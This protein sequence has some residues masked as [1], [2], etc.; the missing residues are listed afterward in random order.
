MA[1]IITLGSESLLLISSKY[2]LDAVAPQS[3]S[4]SSRSLLTILHRKMAPIT[5][6][7]ASGWKASRRAFIPPILSHP[8]LKISEV[9]EMILLQIDIYTLLTSCQ[10]VCRNWR[11]LI[12]TFPSVQK[13]LF[14]TAIKE[15]ELGAGETVPNSLLEEMFPTIFPAQCDPGD[16][17]FE[18]SECAMAKDPISWDRFVR[19][20]ASRHRILVQQPPIQELGLFHIDSAQGGDGTYCISIP[21]RFCNLPSKSGN[22]WLIRCI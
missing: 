2:R 4:L 16:H 8:A 13:A 18:F 5:R 22:P 17:E 19:K 14:F 1:V 15:C 11:N 7:A 10:R 6:L 21:V 3:F 9:L 20:E 12:T